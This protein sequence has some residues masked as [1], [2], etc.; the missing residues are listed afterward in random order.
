MSLK[1]DRTSVLKIALGMH[2]IKK[3]VFGIVLRFRDKNV[4][5]PINKRQL[6]TLREAFDSLLPTPESEY[7]YYA[8]GEVSNGPFGASRSSKS[9]LEYS[10]RLPKSITKIYPPQLR[11]ILQKW[12]MLE[13]EALVNGAS[14]TH[15]LLDVPTVK[16]WPTQLDVLSKDSKPFADLV[17][18]KNPCNGVYACAWPQPDRLVLHELKLSTKWGYTGA[19]ISFPKNPGASLANKTKDQQVAYE[20]RWAISRLESVMVQRFN[21]LDE[22]QSILQAS[23]DQ[24]AGI[25]AALAKAVFGDGD[26]GVEEGMEKRLKKLEEWLAKAAQKE[27]K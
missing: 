21:K 3:P 17:V 6:A 24:F 25:L 23:A 16:D 7:V 15:L 19:P 13:T 20:K 12:L 26:G 14:R 8:A 1:S 27:S 5:D 2:I 9:K 22:A 18:S 4:T 11:D 10:K